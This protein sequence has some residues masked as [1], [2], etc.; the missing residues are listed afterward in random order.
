MN[1]RRH[2]EPQWMIVCYLYTIYIKR[3]SCFYF[4]QY[5]QKRVHS[6]TAT[7]TKKWNK[8]IE[9]V[10][11]YDRDKTIHTNWSQHLRKKN[12]TKC[13][14]EKKIHKNSKTTAKKTWR[15]YGRMRNITTCERLT[16]R[17][18]ERVSLCMQKY[19]AENQN[20]ANTHTQ[21]Q[22][23]QHNRNHSNDNSNS[24]SNSNSNE[25]QRRQLKWMNISSTKCCE[26]AEAP[27]TF[28]GP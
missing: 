22:K 5:N 4:A 1:K 12:L 9:K 6:G 13:N 23:Q 7:T 25:Q 18:R 16:V 14:R 24:N 8:E 2:T 20:K 26:I 17:A 28:I 19:R 11:G 27:K 10:S 15:K 21:T 3:T